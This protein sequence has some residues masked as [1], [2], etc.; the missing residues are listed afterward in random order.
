MYIVN[1]THSGPAEEIRSPSR[2]RRYTP[3]RARNADYCCAGTV[4]R[5]RG[6]CRYERAEGSWR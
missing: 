2:A 6:R 4:H 3:G 1:L 5:H